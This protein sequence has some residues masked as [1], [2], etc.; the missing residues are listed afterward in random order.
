ME[1]KKAKRYLSSI[2]WFTVLWGIKEFVLIPSLNNY[3]SKK[4]NKQNEQINTN[5]K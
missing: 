5:S 2:A 3:K 1:N 4:L